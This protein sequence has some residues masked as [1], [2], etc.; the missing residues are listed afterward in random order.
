MNRVQYF[1][2]AESK[3]R[4]Q[5]YGQESKA[6]SQWEAGYWWASLN[7]GKNSQVC[8]CPGAFPPAVPSIRNILLPETCKTQSLTRSR[9]LLNGLREVFA[10][11]PSEHENL[12][13][14]V[15]IFTL[16]AFLVVFMTTGH[17]L[18]TLYFPT[19]WA[20]HK[21]VTSMSPGTLSALSAVDLRLLVVSRLMQPSNPF[22][23]C[24]TGKLVH[25]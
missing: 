20:S 5:D 23:R 1:F 2:R 13:T 15:Y 25:L 22:V 9:S 7:R 19:E 12:I 6:S 14:T 18:L 17:L 24:C 8:F 10:S 3:P 11:R 21:K 16:L 4:L